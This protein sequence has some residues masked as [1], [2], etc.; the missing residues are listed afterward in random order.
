MKSL[1]LAASILVCCALSGI[2]AQGRGDLATVSVTIGDYI[3]TF[4]DVRLANFSDSRE[5]VVNGSR[6]PIVARGGL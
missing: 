3:G 6:R 4:Y 5:L 2:V 1:V